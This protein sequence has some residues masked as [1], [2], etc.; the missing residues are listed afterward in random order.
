MKKNIRRPVL[1]PYFLSKSLALTS[2]ID[3]TDVGYILSR[4]FKDSFR[5][6]YRNRIDIL[7]VYDA[8]IFI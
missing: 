5:K 4:Y 2:D 6:F 8:I 3:V 7:L 1:P